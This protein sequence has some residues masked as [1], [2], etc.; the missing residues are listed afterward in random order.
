MGPLT[1][2]VRAG[3]AGSSGVVAHQ[4]GDRLGELALV[5]TMATNLMRC[6]QQGGGRQIESPDL[7]F[8]TNKT[9]APCNVCLLIDASASMKGKRLQAATTLA[10]HLVAATRDKVSV[11]VFQESE[12]RLAVPFTRKLQELN[13]GLEM[14]KPY[15]LTPL[16]AGLAYA[17]DY[18]KQS[19]ARNPLLVL[20]SDGIPT[21][22]SST[23]D[24][25]G[26]AIREAGGLRIA[27][28]HFCCIGLEPNH[29]VLAEVTASAKGTLHTVKELDSDALV[30]IVSRAKETIDSRH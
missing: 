27:N 16:A 23:T 25:I 9:H 22:P 7:R 24:P 17:R 18:L 11:V 12:V 14:I 28:V 21:V 6:A 19:K 20:I 26:D 13:A 4:R 1:L 15:G 10:K 30:Q 5:E 3:K 8:R 29:N 2:G